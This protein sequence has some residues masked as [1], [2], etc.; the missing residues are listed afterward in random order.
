MSS[1]RLCKV[2]NAHLR[3]PFKSRF[4]AQAP[5]TESRAA[6]VFRRVASIMLICPG[7]APS[8]ALA[9]PCASGSLPPAAHTISVQTA[10][11]FGKGAADALFA[12]EFAAD[13]TLL[14]GGRVTN[15]SNSFVDV[16]NVGNPLSALGPGTTGTV[17][18][19]STDGVALLARSVFGAQVND[20]AVSH[21]SGDVAVASDIALAVVASD[22]RTLRWAVPGG[23]NRV[24]MAAD[25]RVA[26]LFGKTL[27]VYSASGAQ[28][29]EV[30]LSDALVGDVA[31]DAV[32]GLVFVTGFA[33]RDGSTC[34]QLQVAW[35]RAYEL[36]A[37]G[38]LRWRAYDYPRG[39]ADA[40]G[41]CADTRGR[42]IAMGEDGKLYFVG[43]SAGGNAIY[44]WS[45]QARANIDAHLPA[46][47]AW[48]NAANVTPDGD[49]YVQAFNTASNHISYVARF[50]PATG[51]HEM[52]FFLLSRLGV[53]ADS[54]P[55]GNTIEPRAIAAD[56]EGR[57]YVGG[58]AA[59]Q[60][61]NREL[62]SINGS[63]LPAY[64]GD[65]AWLLITSQDYSKR[66][67]W[68]AFNQ[69]GK[70]T[71]HGIGASRGAVAVAGAI[72]LAPMFVSSNALQS[73]PP[74]VTTVPAER[75]GYFATLSLPESAPLCWLDVDAD[76]VIAPARDGLVLLRALQNLPSNTWATRAGVSS[77]ASNTARTRATVAKSSFALDIDGNGVLDAAS[78]GLLLLRALLGFRGGALIAGA[79]GTPPVTGPWRNT[80]EAVEAYLATRCVR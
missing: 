29:F 62:A 35:I 21:T 32:S 3:T 73:A 72:T 30:A 49:N 37:S 70:A 42:F 51:R 76:G 78:D 77:A 24:A 8:S 28:L 12:A 71:I 10:S 27:R 13:C 15:S 60:I 45:P 80:P 52:G 16:T 6:R 20:L 54:N 23:A 44:R 56:Q 41:D 69:G 59:S 65:D 4:G 2:F 67:V 11:Y 26:A 63:L 14:V 7:I 22:L 18:R 58:V 25:G 75:T 55:R 17:A 68:V 48:P 40:H 39:V 47:S 79:L 38:S 61:K 19:L 31:I 74:S 9:T 64:S 66:D 53:A 46:T 43:T 5:A 1:T 50:D 34:S 36:S 57:V 33:Q